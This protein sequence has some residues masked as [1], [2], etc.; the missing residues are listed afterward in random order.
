M[1]LELACPLSPA[2]YTWHSSDGFLNA[3]EE[4]TLSAKNDHFFEPK[5]GDG[6]QSPGMIT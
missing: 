2:N 5:C 1:T 3:A 4:L 6:Q